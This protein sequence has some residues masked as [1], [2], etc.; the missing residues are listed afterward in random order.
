[1]ST[2][3]DRLATALRAYAAEQETLPARESWRGEDRRAPRGPRRR[4]GLLVLVPVAAC[5]AALFLLQPGRDPAPASAAEL[6]RSAATAAEQE[7]PL[8]AG[9]YLYVRREFTS[10]LALAPVK[11][12]TEERWTRADG[13]GRTLVRDRSGR[14]VEDT[15]RKAGFVIGA[16]RV[17]RLTDARG[18]L[19]RQAR[20][21]IAQYPDVDPTQMRAFT[22]Y[23][24][25]RDLLDTPSAAALRAE[26]FRTLAATPGLRRAGDATVVARVGDVQFRLRLDPGSGRILGTERRLLRRSDQ[27]PGPPGVVDHSVVVARAM[28]G[29]TRARP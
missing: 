29:S 19:E 2:F 13:S 11:A 8:P 17:T 10:R 1:M 22:A 20:R 5:L 18:R 12:G 14:V 28:V 4:R 26:A 24:I 7:A 6:L 16:D 23:T 27:L 9:A 25:L 21:A 15:R 3:E